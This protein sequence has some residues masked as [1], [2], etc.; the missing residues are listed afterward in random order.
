MKL[1]ITPNVT[2]MSKLPVMDT[3]QGHPFDGHLPGRS[4][5]PLKRVD[6]NLFLS[7]SLNTIDEETGDIS[8]I[9]VLHRLLL[10]CCHTMTFFSRTDYVNHIREKYDRMKEKRV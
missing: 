3:L 2:L 4:I 8:F 6:N 7:T 5:A 9:Y 1:T 10:R